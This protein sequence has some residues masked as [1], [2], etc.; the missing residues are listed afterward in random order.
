MP[1]AERAHIDWN[2][3]L[4]R[5]IDLGAPSFGR[6]ASDEAPLLADV[7]LNRAANQWHKIIGRELTDREM[8]MNTYITLK[9][10]SQ[11]GTQIF[12]KCRFNTLLQKLMT[13]YCQRQGVA[14]NSVRFLF[15]GERLRESQTPEYL[16]MEDGDVIDVMME[17]VGD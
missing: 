16:E 13:A 3:A 9:I 10:I 17:Q 8:H 14:M 6:T 4:E 5:W 12:F 2:L 11:D 15:D 1:A 7:T